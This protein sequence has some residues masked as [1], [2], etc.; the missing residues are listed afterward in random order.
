[1]FRHQFTIKPSIDLTPLIND[2]NSEL[3]E[4]IK[5]DL[6]H[7]RIQSLFIVSCN[8]GALMIAKELLESNSSIDIHTLLAQPRYAQL[9]MFA[10]P[11][12]HFINLSERENVVS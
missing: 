2:A 9:T 6:T 5:N 10:P 11:A 8:R 3:F 4:M 7:N 12:F 1:M